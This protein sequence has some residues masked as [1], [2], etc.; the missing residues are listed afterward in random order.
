M[1]VVLAGAG[2]YIGRH[3][4]RELVAAGADVTTIG[5]SQPERLVDLINGDGTPVALVN[6]AGATGADPLDLASANIDL[7]AALVAAAARAGSAVRLVH[8]GSAAEYGRVDPGHASRESDPARPI[9]LYGMSKL[10]GTRIVEAAKAFGLDAV[11]LRVTN[12]VGPGAPT[13]GLPGALAAEIRRAQAEGDAVRVGP[14]DAVRDFVDVR[15]VARAVVAAVHIPTLT[16]STVN[17]GSG[18]A[19]VAGELVE[20]LVALSGYRGDVRPVG[21]ASSRSAAVPWQQADITLAAEV[22][23]WRPQRTLRTALTA[24]WAATASE[25]PVPAR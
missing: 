20:E 22:L 6:C 4:R 21:E 8:L 10:A 12:P 19:T 2:G 11:V 9:G 14:L 17:V 24:L 7:P 13:T 3:V 15:D 18:R 16:A 1:R 25:S 5:R 23:D